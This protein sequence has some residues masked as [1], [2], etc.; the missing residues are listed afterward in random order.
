MAAFDLDSLGVGPLVDWTESH[1]DRIRRAD[2]GDGYSEIAPD[3]INTHKTLVS[4]EYVVDNPQR[5]ALLAGLKQTKGADTI[6][7]TKPDEVD[8]HQWLREGNYTVQRY[9]SE[10]SNIKFTL[11]RFG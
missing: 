6:S 3:G 9:N 5:K 10:L 8:Q 11:Y 7:W 4:L 2:F 1:S